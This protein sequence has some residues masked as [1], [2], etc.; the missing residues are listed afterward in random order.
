MNQL[1][2]HQTTAPTGRR[3]ATYLGIPH[4]TTMRDT[5]TRPDFL[6]RWGSAQAVPLKPENRTFN[7]RA[8]VTAASNKLTALTTLRRAGIAIPRF[9]TD[10]DRL[11][12]PMLARRTNTQGGRD[13]H[14]VLQPLDVDQI[15][16]QIDF[17][18]EYIP[19]QAEYRLHVAGGEI[20]KVQVKDYRGEAEEYDPVIWNHNAGWFF[21]AVNRRDAHPGVAQAITAV[22]ALGLD[23]GAVDLVI[24]TDDRPYVLEVNTAPGLCINTLHLY[25]EYFANEMNLANIPGPDAVHFDD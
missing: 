8:S 10:Q 21:V 11:T 24:G 25:G 2:Y 20:I 12:Y 14:L 1:L 5:T 22:G 17:F 19:K 6:I 3:L 15:A 23:F 9:G 4:G 18:C 16:G 13:I 7:K